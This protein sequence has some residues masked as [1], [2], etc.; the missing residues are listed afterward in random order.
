MDKHLMASV[1]EIRGER[2]K[3]V[4]IYREILRINP[5][6]K[7]AENNLRRI[8]S[9]KNFAKHANTDMLNFFK[10][11]SSIEELYE[12]ERWLGGN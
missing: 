1:Y 5:S 2:E 11:A 12:L 4:S 10:K 6:D 3:A 9:R 8:A 7:R